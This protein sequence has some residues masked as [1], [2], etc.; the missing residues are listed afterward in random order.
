MNDLDRRK[1]KKVLRALGRDY[2]VVV[3]IPPGT[4]VPAKL[5]KNERGKA[6]EGQKV[7]IKMAQLGNILRYGTALTP[8]RDFIAVAKRMY[9]KEW[10]EDFARIV[11]HCIIRGIDPTLPLHGL[12]L[13][14]VA[15]I[16]EAILKSDEYKPNSPLTL[17][18]KQGK[19]PLIDRR[20]FINSF[21]VLNVGG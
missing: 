8:A 20:N 5:R 9:E 2:S 3:G 18:Q 4:E 6:V 1:L 12:G 19:K 21:D 14:M 15:N 17:A 16:K 13:K 7:K 10:R 11:Q